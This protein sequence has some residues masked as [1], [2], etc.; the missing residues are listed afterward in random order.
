LFG[1]TDKDADGFVTLE[2]LAASMQGPRD[3]IAAKIKEMDA[4]GDG[5]ISQE[6]WKGRPEMFGKLDKNGDG[7]LTADEM[8][9][10]GG[11]K[12]PRKK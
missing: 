3:K 2:E 6:E 7:S 8:Q 9:A 12:G 11:D 10:M 1:K 5:A 4:D